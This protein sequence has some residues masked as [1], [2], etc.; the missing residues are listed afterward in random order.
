MRQDVY[1]DIASL[2]EWFDENEECF[3]VP[4][5]EKNFKEVSFNNQINFMREHLFFT[6]KIIENDQYSNSQKLRKFMKMISFGK[7][8]IITIIGGRGSGKTAFAMYT[9]EK[10]FEEGWHKNIFY[11]KRG[12]RPDWL[13]SWIKSATSM[14]DIPNKCFAILDETVLEYGARNFHDDAN[15][16]FTERLVILRHKDT[17]VMLVTQNSKLIDINIRRL[18]DILVYKRGANLEKENVEDEE[19]L[20]ILR[21][22]MPHNANKAIIE[23]KQYNTFW[24]VETGLASFWDDESVSKTYKDYNPEA[25][26]RVQ[27]TNKYKEE[28]KH[29]Q[30]KENIRAEAMAAK[31]L[32]KAERKVK[33][34]MVNPEDFFDP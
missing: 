20:L 9:I 1:E 26:K 33:R 25:H 24:S 16:S 17:S 6:K 11:V 2:E 7:S 19:R 32:I 23:I 29:I 34:Q 8:K 14:E 31:N 4:Y 22:L 13:P 5:I 12:E 3:I 15:K 30:E 10:L 18:S 27:R 28:I 21:R